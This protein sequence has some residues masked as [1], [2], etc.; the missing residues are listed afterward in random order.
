MIERV[1][2]PWNRYDDK[3]VYKSVHNECHFGIPRGAGYIRFKDGFQETFPVE[4]YL[5]LFDLAAHNIQEG[6]SGNSSGDHRALITGEHMWKCLCV[7]VCV[8]VCVCGRAG[9]VWYHYRPL[10]IRWN[11]V[12][13]FKVFIRGPTWIP[14]MKSLLLSFPL[15]AGLAL[16]QWIPHMWLW[17]QKH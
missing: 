10:C 4:D 3:E 1:C 16:F 7:G 11:D 15:L 12:R 14:T 8:V 9:M 17:S 6:I 13:P 5:D 2:N